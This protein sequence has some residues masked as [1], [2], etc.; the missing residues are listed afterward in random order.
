MEP[1]YKTTDYLTLNLLQ[2][3]IKGRLK[4]SNFLHLFVM[5]IID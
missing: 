3:N 4:A 5:L 2:K 1:V